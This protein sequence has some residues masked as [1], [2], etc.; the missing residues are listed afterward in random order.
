MTDLAAFAPTLILVLALAA[1]FVLVLWV[2]LPFAVFGSKPLL[3]ELIAQQKQT[4]ELPN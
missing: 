3:R 1:L 2:L 4:N